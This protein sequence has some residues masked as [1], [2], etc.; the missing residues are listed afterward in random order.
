MPLGEERYCCRINDCQPSA[1]LLVKNIGRI[2][3]SVV[4]ARTKFIRY[5]KQT[6]APMLQD[7]AGREGAQRHLL[8]GKTGLPHII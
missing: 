2:D 4:R 6:F 7:N 1:E 8:E 5:S 3:A